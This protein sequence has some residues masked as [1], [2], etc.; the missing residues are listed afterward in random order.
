MA[1]ERRLHPL[2][3]LFAI[4]E[5][6]KQFIVPAIVALF[7][8]RG[9]SWEIL[10]GVVVI[11][12]ALVALARALSV[13]YA[14][15]DTEFVLRSGFFFKRVRHIP[16]ERVQNVDAVQNILHRAVGVMDVR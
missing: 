15:E 7:A 12:L 11:P 16:Y 4:Q 5:T 3:F 1:S 13:R 9:D 14:F 8:A 6:A 10:A 2:S